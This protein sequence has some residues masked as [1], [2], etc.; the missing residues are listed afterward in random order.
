MTGAGEAGDA[1]Q[2]QTDASGHNSKAQI[3]QMTISLRDDWLHRGDALQDMDLQ[4]YAEHIERK[5]KPLRGTDMQKVMKQT[6]F[7]FD[8][9]Y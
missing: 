5:A 7:A 9:H 2:V 8:S 1:E 3:F 4:T 6:I